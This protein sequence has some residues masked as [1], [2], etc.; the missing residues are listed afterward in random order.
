VLHPD[1]VTLFRL[2]APIFYAH[3]I[4]YDVDYARDVQG[5]P[6][7]VVHG[8]LTAALLAGF[9]CAGCLGLKA[10]DLRAHAPLFAGQSLHLAAREL[11]DRVD[12]WAPRDDGTLAMTVALDFQTSEPALM[13]RYPMFDTL[14]ALTRK[15]PRGCRNPTSAR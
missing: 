1:Q 11:G 14:L 9:R 15:A 6:E 12:T 5:F 8:P 4:H 7:L 2:S 3:R 13:V 10:F